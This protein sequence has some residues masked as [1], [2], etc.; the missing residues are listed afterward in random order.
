M[1][2]KTYIFQ[3]KENRGFKTYIFKLKENRRLST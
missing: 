2:F 1:Y 3:L